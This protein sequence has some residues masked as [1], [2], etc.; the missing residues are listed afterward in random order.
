MEYYFY[1]IIQ[2]YFRNVNGIV[3]DA[4][5]GFVDGILKIVMY[6]MCF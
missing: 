4:G 5:G 6:E 2:D 3:S 1:F